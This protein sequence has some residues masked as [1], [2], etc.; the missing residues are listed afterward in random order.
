LGKRDGA[1]HGPAAIALQN[2]ATEPE[3]EFNGDELRSSPPLR[4]IILDDEATIRTTLT[5]CLEAAGHK[6]TSF[7]TGEPA[8]ESAGKQAFDLLFLDLRLGT[9]N[10][11]DYIPRFLR[12][13]P[14]LK[15]IVITAY[16]SIDTAVEAMRRGAWDYLPKPFTPEHVEML[17]GK[18]AHERSLEHRWRN[19]RKRW[20]RIFRR[21]R[22]RPTIEHFEPLNNWRGRLP[23][24]R[25]RSCCTASRH[26][27]ADTGPRDA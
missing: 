7:G 16:A 10:G 11:L 6:V 4:I 17:A 5:L 20:R 13:S 15:I 23:R 18:I 9:E 25:R 14:W 2:L 8:L 3:H 19:W 22:Y 24:P 26:G 27:K 21:C 12:Q 1:C